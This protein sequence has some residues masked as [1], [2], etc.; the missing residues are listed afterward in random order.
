MKKL[1]IGMTGIHRRNHKLIEEVNKSDSNLIAYITDESH[2]CKM[3][4]KLFIFKYEL[5]E[6]LIVVHHK[7][8]ICD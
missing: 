1:E 5:I 2:K 8:T 6:H 4:Q 3:C 7:C